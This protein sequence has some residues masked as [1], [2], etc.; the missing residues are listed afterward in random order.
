MVAT[1]IEMPKFGLA[2]EEGTIT[3]WFKAVGDAVAKGEPVAEV[4]TEKITNTVEA[5][6]SG[7]LKKILVHAGE[8]AA[9]GGAIGIIASAQ[10]DISALPGSTVQATAAVGQPEIGPASVPAD[11]P[12]IGVK[13]TPRAQKFAE[14]HGLDYCLIPGTGI[15]GAVTIDDLKNY[16]TKGSARKFQAVITPEERPLGELRKTIAKRMMESLAA[17]AQTTMSMDVDA[18]RLVEL[19]KKRK[20][21][22]QEEGI[23][24]TY[25]AFLVK[26]VAVAL[27]K[28]PLFRTKLSASGRLKVDAGINIGIA[29]DM[30]DGLVV[31]VLKNADNKDLKTI[32]KELETL[33]QKARQKQLDAEEMTG[34]VITVSNLGMFGVKYF[35]PILNFPESSIL[36]VGALTEQLVVQDGGIFVKHMLN[37]SLTHDH[38]IIDGAPAARFLTEIKNLLGEPLGL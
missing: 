19:Y 17:S 13:I 18:T 27:G 38:R 7:V 8:T 24:L 22:Y 3:S 5:P 2:M 12:A 33:S 4:I 11:K 10:E 34:G 29:V 6:A 1:Y 20:A 14:E 23:K 31:P 36:G 28:H 35:T 37:L 30:E 15:G 21:V 32:C 26:A 9:C 16:L 25:T